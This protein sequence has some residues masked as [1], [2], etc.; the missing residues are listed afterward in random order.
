MNT[1]C[2]SCGNWRNECTCPSPFNMTDI[3]GVVGEPKPMT[4]EQLEEIKARA[5]KYYPGEVVITEE[6]LHAACDEGDRKRLGAY[7]ADGNPVTVHA[8]GGIRDSRGIPYFSDIPPSCL[9]RL[10][11]IYTEGHRR[12][13]SRN[14]CKGLPYSDTYNH[15]MNH[16]EKYR[17]GDRSEDHLAK[18]AWGCFTM[19]WLDE[20][21]SPLGLNDLAFPTDVDEI[22]RLNARG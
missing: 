15:I 20:N 10:A 14:W 12:Y 8:G 22:N 5:E 7:D 13:G 4:R 19:M 1:K 11:A 9:R 3:S 17:A 2:P 6:M 18:V 21:L 16:L